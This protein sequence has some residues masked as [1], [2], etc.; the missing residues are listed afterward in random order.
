M[1]SDWV[2]LA[3]WALMLLALGVAAV[4]GGRLAARLFVHATDRNDG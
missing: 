2:S 1:P 4:V 3:F